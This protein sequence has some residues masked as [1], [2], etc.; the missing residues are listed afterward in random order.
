MLT[1]IGKHYSTAKTIHL[2]LDISARTPSGPAT[3]MKQKLD[4]CLR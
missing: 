4:L 2:A 3:E 1:R